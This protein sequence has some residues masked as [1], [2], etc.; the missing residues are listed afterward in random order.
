MKKI[1]SVLLLLAVLPYIL[2]VGYAEP[3]QPYY[4][5]DRNDPDAELANLRLLTAGRYTLKPLSSRYGLDSDYTPSLEGMDTLHISGSVEFSEQQFRALAQTLRECAGGDPIYVVDLRQESHALINGT[6]VSLYASGNAANKGMSTAQVEADERQR[7]GSMPGTTLVAYSGREYTPQTIEVES[8]MTEREL[9]QSE[10]I[11]YLRIAATDHLWPEANLVDDFIDF[12]KGVDMNHVWLHFHC[13]AGF[14]RTAIFMC[15]YDMMKNP[16][17]PVE[18]IVARQAMTGGEYLLHS[19]GN[20]L[21]IEEDKSKMIRLAYQYIQENRA[22]NY[23]VR[24]S[25]W[26]QEHT[27]VEMPN[28][29]DYDVLYLPNDLTV[30][31]EQAFAETAC[32]IVVIPESCTEIHANAFNGASQLKYIII[33]ADA[34]THVSRGAFDGTDATIIRDA[35]N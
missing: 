8:C 6:S 11:G 35:E 16:D 4:R 24:W 34:K 7:F 21:S 3:D 29:D 9:A 30:I 13:L 18:D 15:I 1:L 12:V 32:E 25:D 10:G 27:H 26:V 31:E 17:V 2:A 28:L 23:S 19:S 20:A 22:T 5:I 33:P 14:G